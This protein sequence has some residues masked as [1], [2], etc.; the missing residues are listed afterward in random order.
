MKHFSNMDMNKQLLRAI[1]DLDFEAIIDT[2]QDEGIDPDQRD[3]A[4]GL[5]TILMR[6]CHLHLDSEKRQEI[7]DLIMDKNPN[8]NIQDSSGR[9]ALVHACIAE[10]L[11]IIQGLSL[12]Q[13]CNPNIV[14]DDENSALTYTVRSR[15]VNVVQIFLESFKH[16]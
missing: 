13:D 8:I 4:H 5:Q 10:K 2:L 16:H 9:T 7:F 14:D 3:V 6:L 15:N 1:S 12:R 11:D